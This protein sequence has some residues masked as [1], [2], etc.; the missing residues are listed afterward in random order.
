MIG[1]VWAQAENGVIGAGGAIPWRIPED[2]KHFRGV[3][4]GHPVVMGRRTWDSLP[5]RF[6]PL[7]GRTNIVVTRDRSWAADGAV[8]A[9]SV[10][11]A[12]REG[13]PAGGDLWVIG[14]GEI[15]RAALPLADVLEVTEVAGE[16]DGDAYAPAI[17]PAVFTVA[18]RTEWLASSAGPRYR[19]VTYR[20]R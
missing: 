15:Y 18:A 20:A 16:Y 11:A 6:R 1:L 10:D 5:D 2:A 7:P 12:V 4:V 3:T 14:G 19:F 17:D 9:A 8:P 13:V